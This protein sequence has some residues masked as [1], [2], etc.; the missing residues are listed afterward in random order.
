MTTES[1]KLQTLHAQIATLTS[2]Q[3]RIL[4]LRAIPA[5]VLRSSDTSILSGTP[6]IPVALQDLKDATTAL[7]DTEVQDA[8]KAAAESIKADSKGVR[9]GGRREMRKRRYVVLDYLSF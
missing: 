8:L 7:Q 5:H 4:H 3:N 1:T 2:F 9:I 6:S